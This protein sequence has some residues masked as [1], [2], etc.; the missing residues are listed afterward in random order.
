M[1]A[2]E[3]V[4]GALLNHLK[5]CGDVAASRAREVFQKTG[6]HDSGINLAFLY[7]LHDFA[8]AQ[9]LNTDK[10]LIKGFRVDAAAH[11]FL[12]DLKNPGRKLAC[13]GGHPLVGEVF[14][15]GDVS[16]AGL[17]DDG[18]GMRVIGVGVV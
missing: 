4:T 8:H 12:G 9:R 13:D 11:K 14:K 7:H 16:S 2:G 10:A 18:R 3:T 6:P 5:P 15:G 1:T 17:G